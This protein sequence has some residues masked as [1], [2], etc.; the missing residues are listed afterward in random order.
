MASTVPRGA[1][2]RATSMPKSRIA[3]VPAGRSML[4]RVRTG[5]TMMPSSPAILRRS[6]LTRSSR[7]PPL[8]GST[9]SMMSGDSS[10]PSGSTRISAASSSGVSGAR[11]ERLLRDHVRARASS[12][13]VTRLEA[14]SMIPPA[15]TKG[16]LGRPGIRQIASA[17]NPAICS[18]SLLLVS[19][20]RMSEPMSESPTLRVTMRPVAVESSSAGICETRPSPTDSRL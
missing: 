20:R 3:Y 13:V 9:R 16:S 5:G 11:G 14:S 2:P 18:G 7:S 19:C 4:S 1:S 8:A 6:A 12:G 10:R 17:A 15:T